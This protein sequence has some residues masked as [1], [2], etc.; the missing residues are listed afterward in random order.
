[1]STK[2]EIIPEL[3]PQDLHIRNMDEPK[4]PHKGG[5]DLLI[6][7]EG[8]GSRRQVSQDPVEKAVSED[9]CM[10]LLAR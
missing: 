4:S 9:D 3:G 6:K 2:D 8:P 10:T 5:D 1:V 7:T